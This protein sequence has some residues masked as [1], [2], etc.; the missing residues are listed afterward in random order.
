MLSMIFVLLIGCGKKTDT[1]ST[2]AETEQTAIINKDE[3]QTIS[4]SPN[5]NTKGNTVSASPTNSIEIKAIVRSDNAETEKKDE[6]ILPLPE[7]ADN[8]DD[9]V[10][11]EKSE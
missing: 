10:D 2:S 6:D 3:V 8:I 9:T 7:D 11:S 1:T 4:L 5:S